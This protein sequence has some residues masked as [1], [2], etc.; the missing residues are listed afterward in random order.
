MYRY[1]RL[2][3]L[4]D[5]SICG[6]EKGHHFHDV[7]RVGST[8]FEPVTPAMSRQC[9]TPEP[10]THLPTK[11]SIR[12]FG[13]G[14]QIYSEENI[15]LRSSSWWSFLSQLPRLAIEML[16]LYCDSPCGNVR[17]T[18]EP[19]RISLVEW[20]ARLPDNSRLVSAYLAK[21]VILDSII[22]DLLDG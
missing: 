22:L 15:P 5:H 2:L 1:L 13:A 9:S 20:L 21:Y 16:S 12:Y 11:K 14:C 7:L 18:V 3:Q 6:H 8:G 19:Q 4:I 17:N 10:T